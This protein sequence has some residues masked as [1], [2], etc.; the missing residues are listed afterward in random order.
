MMLKPSL[1]GMQQV[2]YALIKKAQYQK[3]IIFDNVG[4]K[5]GKEMLDVLLDSIR[6]GGSVEL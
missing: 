5:C 1:P 3:N 4:I 2:F 6:G